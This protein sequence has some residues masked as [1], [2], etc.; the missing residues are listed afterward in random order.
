[1]TL[2]LLSKD[3]G[4]I[5]L[6]R[7]DTTTFWN[8]VAYEPFGYVGV[9]T[10]DGVIRTGGLN[11]TLGSTI[12]RTSNAISWLSP[13]FSGVTAQLQMALSE[14][15]TACAAAGGVGNIA[16]VSSCPGASGDGKVMGGRLGYDR[17]PL[18]LGAS[19]STTS[20]GPIAA[21]LVSPY[22]ANAVYGGLGSLFRQG[23][24][25]QTNLGGSYDLGMAKLF[26]QWGTQTLKASTGDQKLTYWQISASA[27]VGPWVPKAGYT[28]GK[29][30][31]QTAGGGLTGAKQDLWAVG[32]VYN[33]SKRTVAYVTYANNKMKAG[34][35]GSVNAGA[36]FG[37]Q[38][39]ALA[40]GT[41][42]PARRVWTWASVTRSDRTLAS[43]SSD[44]SSGKP[45]VATRW[46]F[47]VQ[48]TS[49]CSIP[50]CGAASPTSSP[51]TSPGIAKTVWPRSRWT[52]PTARTRS[53]SSP[54]PSCASCSVRWPM[55]R[56]SRRWCS[57]APAA[58]SAPAVTCTKSS[59]RWLSMSMPELIE[60]TRMTGD[61]VLAMRKCPQPIIAAIDGICAGAGTMIALAADFRLGTPTAK[62]AWLFT[63]VGLAGCDMGACTLLPR[64]IGQGRASGTA[65]HGP[66]HDGA[67]RDSPGVSR[68][69]SSRRISCCPS[70]AHWP[71]RW[72]RVRPSRMG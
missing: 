25:I 10:V 13:N 16:A 66:R 64:M 67:T 52:A 61:L 46:V 26:G 37:I 18:S 6:G 4:E 69:G 70:P 22:A 2:S 45:T 17:G 39:A 63:R 1:M 41:S 48:E 19:T 38:A 72:S 24:A 62:A 29:R 49:R 47:F 30:D 36:A 28:T 40:A 20:Y 33:F 14:V 44:R 23:D 55:R 31:D 59:A 3:F 60:F 42:P 54:T 32:G 65:V 68:T 12:V 8:M 35:T 51:A 56:M 43:A 71:A 27:P 15:P 7:D 21:A 9:G 53:R 57:P 11:P 58:T 50:V 34:A 5:R